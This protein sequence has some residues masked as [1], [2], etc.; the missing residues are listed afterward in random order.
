MLICWKC[1]IS[2]NYIKNRVWK[3]PQFKLIFFQLIKLIFF[4]YSGEINQKSEQNVLLFK[5]YLLFIAIT[6]YWLNKLR[7]TS[8]DILH[9]IE[10]NPGNG[11]WD[12][13]QYMESRRRKISKRLLIKNNKNL[14]HLQALWYSSGRE[15]MYFLK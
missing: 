10:R 4:F 5:T 6:Q 12:R 8:H 15:K 1:I 14:L 9:K 11:K 3:I 7:W 13:Y 2:T